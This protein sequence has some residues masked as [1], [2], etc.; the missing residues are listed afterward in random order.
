MSEAPREVW[1][2]ITRLVRGGAQR[3]ALDLAGGLDRARFTPVLLAGAETGP[4]GSLWPEAE[5]LGIEIIRLPSLVRSVS[6]WRD[7]RAL[8]EVGRLIRERRPAGS[9][10]GTAERSACV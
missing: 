5:A 9:R 7:L 3:I 2:G 8:R 1:Q 10:T 6:P 4:E